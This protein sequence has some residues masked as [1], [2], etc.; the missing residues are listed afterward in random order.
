MYLEYYLKQLDYE[1][2]PDFL[3]QYLICPSLVR[4]KDVGYFCGMDYASKDIYDFREYI[5]RYAHSLTVAL[6]TYKLTKDKKATIAGLCH[7]IATPCFSHVI[8]YMNKDYE[9]QE[10]T[11]AYTEKII[12]SDEYLLACLKRDKIDIKDIIN[13]KQFPVVDND[14]PRLCADRLDGVILTGIGWTKNITL[15]D[16]KKIIDDVC[17]TKNEDGV[18]EIGFKTYSVAKKVLEISESIDIICHSNEDNYMMELLA[19]ITKYAIDMGYITY[20]ELYTVTEKY[21]FQKLYSI[22]DDYLKDMLKKFKHIKREEIE[23][24]N[25]PKLKIRDLNPLVNNQRIKNI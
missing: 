11:E 18:D 6:L 22:P 5:S 17:L 1:H 12:R 23:E 16:I 13:F 14:R 7:D 24:T 15:E 8:D 2:F 21:L 9:H 3:I 10:S 25:L 19:S 20:D 4:L